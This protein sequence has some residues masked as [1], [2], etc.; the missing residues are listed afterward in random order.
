MYKLYKLPESD[1]KKYAMVI[2][3]EANNDSLNSKNLEKQ[4]IVK[5][6]QKPY[7][8]YLI[9]SKEKNKDAYRHKIRYLSRHHRDEF[10]NLK[11]AGCYSRWILWNFEKMKD[12]IKHMERIFNIKI[13]YFP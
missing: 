6:G 12:N 3:P 5:F 7:K 11:K 13:Q 9:Y 1:E 10:M 8:D 4:T 2:P